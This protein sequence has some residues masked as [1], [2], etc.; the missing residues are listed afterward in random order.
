M[1]GRA[2]DLCFMGFKELAEQLETG[3]TSA[4]EVAEAHLERIASLDHVLNGFITVTHDGALE[5]ARAIDRELLLRRPRRS[6]LLGAPVA[7][8]DNVATA[9]VTTTA[10]CRA[11]AENVPA[12]DASIVTSLREAGTVDL[13]KTNLHELACGAMESYGVTRNA[14]DLSRA[15]GGSSSGSATVVA[16]GMAVAATGT[17]TGGSIRV[18]ASFSGV[19]GFKPTYGLVDARGILPI[20]RTLDSPA[21]LTRSA[22]DAAQLLHVLSEP[23]GSE[24]LIGPAVLAGKTIG[25]ATDSLERT[26]EEGG[27][28]REV[29]AAIRAA[30][31]VLEGLGAQIVEVALPDRHE[32]AA[33]HHATWLHE[34]VRCLHR[35]LFEETERV[36]LVVRNR[37]RPG[38]LLSDADY[39]IA[40]RLRAR[41]VDRLARTF[42]KADAVLCPATPFPAYRLDD[43]VRARSDVSRFNRLTNLSGNPSVALPSGF[44]REGLP[45]GMQL[46]GRH[47]E[48]RQLLGIAMAYQSVTAW[49]ERRP[50]AAERHVLAEAAGEAPALPTGRWP[51]ATAGLPPLEPHMLPTLDALKKRSL[52]AGLGLDDSELE[53]ATRQLYPTLTVLAASAAGGQ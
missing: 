17:E 40:G 51:A 30:A 31:S 48:D 12:E 41:V 32:V 16:A 19:V 2:D 3:R 34:A 1:A 15:A 24:P 29:G 50:D 6:G 42:E 47:G 35:F 43:F 8:K 23:P 11:L 37:L 7:H 21:W 13:G 4:L 5:R 18:P 44:D 26:V 33:A 9:G 36:G 39:A 49:H 27:V 45:L 22:F 53:S 28:E 38:A 20:S 14:W 10:A 25:L 52:A 46:I